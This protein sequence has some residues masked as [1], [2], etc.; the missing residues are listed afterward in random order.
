MMV[1]LYRGDTVKYY[2]IGQFSN[3]VKKMIKEL[4]END[5]SKES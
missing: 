2:I 4:L 1:S 3:K 5:T